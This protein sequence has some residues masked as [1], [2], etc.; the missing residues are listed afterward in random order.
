MENEGVQDKLNRGNFDE[1]VG[2]QDLLPV[3]AHYQARAEHQL[4]EVRI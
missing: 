1:I 4:E 3:D 2:Q